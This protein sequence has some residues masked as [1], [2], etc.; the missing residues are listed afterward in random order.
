E[1]KN[2]KFDNFTYE[3]KVNKETFDIE[4]IVMDFGIGM[5][6]EGVV[7]GIKNKSTTKYSDFNAVPTITIPT[8]ALENAKS[9]EELSA[10]EANQ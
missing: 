1:M 3:F 9:M 6:M 10:L 8:E 2:I 7:M 4:E 5:N